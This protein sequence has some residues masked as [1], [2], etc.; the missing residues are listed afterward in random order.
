MPYSSYHHDL[1]NHG[2]ASAVR[3]EPH[4]PLVT[5]SR[6]PNVYRKIQ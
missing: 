3:S 4:F 6:L 5:L 2:A 1:Q